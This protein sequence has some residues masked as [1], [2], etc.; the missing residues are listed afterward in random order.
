MSGPPI[1][2]GS[3]TGAVVF[4]KR[5]REDIQIWNDQFDRAAGMRQPIAF[6]V[7]FLFTQKPLT[8]GGLSG[9]VVCMITSE[10]IN[11]E[12]ATRYVVGSAD[13]A[14]AERL[15]QL[16]L[17]LY[18]SE[19]AHLVPENIEAFRELL[20]QTLTVN[21][22]GL[23]ET[24]VVRDT[25]E[26]NRIVASVVASTSRNP[27]RSPLTRTHATN[28]VRR[29]GAR[30]AARVLWTQLQLANLLCASL[31]HRTTQLHSLIIDPAHR[32]Q[33]LG[34]RLVQAVEDHA[35]QNGD[36]HILLYILAGNEVQRFY[37]KLGY[38][39]RELPGRHR[40]YYPGIAMTRSLS[41]HA[42]SEA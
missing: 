34:A 22:A 32:G 14:D 23:R 40:I 11:T 16:L 25:H 26:S 35:I 13:V 33:Y 18:Q 19:C 2:T 27:R 6:V 31:P 36:E 4:R 30:T 37:Q 5:C 28:T 41:F 12:I 8:G 29:L 42:A 7:L 38:T 10:L 39:Q 21:P 17:E 20:R 9:S 15:A 1:V 24:F 3:V